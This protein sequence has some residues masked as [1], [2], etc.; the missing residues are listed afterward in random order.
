[1]PLQ[2]YDRIFFLAMMTTL[3]PYHDLTFTALPSLSHPRSP[4]DRPALSAI[5]APT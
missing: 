2:A 5:R 3:H 4:A 1:M